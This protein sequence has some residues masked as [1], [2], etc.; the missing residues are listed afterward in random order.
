MKRRRRLST[1]ATAYHEAGHAV[2]AHV[3]SHQIKRITI[4]PNRLEN[5]K[6]CVYFAKQPNVKGIDRDPSP[7]ITRAAQEK[8]LTSLAG[9]CAQRVFN[10]RTCRSLH[11]Y[12]DYKEVLLYVGHLIRE[13]ET[14]PFLKWMEVRTENILRDNWKAVEVLAEELIRRH[15]I[16]GQ[17]AHRIIQN[18]PFEPKWH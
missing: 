13:N 14:E 16:G 7:R 6:G 3:L 17:E 1:E 15:E 5:Y 11:G 18:S 12:E 9:L 2:A 10:P 4:V 8:I